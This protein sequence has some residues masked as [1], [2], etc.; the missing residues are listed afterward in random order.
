MLTRQRRAAAIAA[1]VAIGIA[2]GVAGA[3][4]TA[5]GPDKDLKSAAGEPSPSAKPSA[6]SFQ[7]FST[8]PKVEAS[9]STK[10]LNKKLK[11]LTKAHNR[12]VTAHNE[13]VTAHNNLGREFD[14]LAADYY[15]C[16]T[17]A[18]V[19]QYPGYDYEG[20]IGATT[21]LDFTTPGDPVDAR[22][23]VYNC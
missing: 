7:R 20:F 17:I 1:V 19:T 11:K 5:E 2:F 15:N 14:A 10:K 18:N 21:A 22:M 3:T 8:A 6:R 9:V 16:E 12:L 4:A 13:L 23:V